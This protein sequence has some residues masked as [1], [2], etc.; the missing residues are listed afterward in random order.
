MELIFK[1]QTQ[2]GRAEDIR[3]LEG[4][5]IT[6]GR[7][8]DNDLIVSDT[9]VSPHH[10]MIATD[11]NG[12]LILNDLNSLNGIYSDHN[13]KID[14]KAALN[15]GS[16][17]RIGKTVIRLFSPDHPVPDALD[18]SEVS[19]L[20]QILDNPFAFVIAIILVSL[21][22]A[23]DQWLNMFAEFKWQE[24]INTELVVLGGALLTGIFWSVIGRVFKHE[25]NLKKQIT[26]ILV[27]ILA[28]FLL[29]SL[30]EL[31]LFNTLNY[32]FS[33]AIMLI[34]EFCLIAALLWC[35]LLL[36]V[37]QSSIQRI[38]TA[39]SVSMILIALS[40]YSEF[41]FDSEVSN[42]PEY[43]KLLSPPALQLTNAISED[44]YLTSI[45]VVFDKLNSE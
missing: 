43:V 26:V 2:P 19:T 34:F 40:L 21:I 5:R 13:Q 41:N 31:I 17:F 27:F 25:A 10:A 28:Q 33:L 12:H 7:A 30:F 22:H 11:E 9:E 42:N 6:I 45:M 36:A 24:I 23:M 18:N 35:N 1:I 16:Q 32:Y 38:R 20:P 4:E 29:T 15:S 14:S 44:D 39:V 8:F 37:N 3:K